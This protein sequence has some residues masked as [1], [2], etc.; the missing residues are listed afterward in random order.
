VS[1][2]RIPTPAPKVYTTP[3]VREGQK[4]ARPP[5]CCQRCGITPRGR[6]PRMYV[7]THPSGRPSIMVDGDCRTYL[8]H[9]GWTE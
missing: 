6:S 7:V 8:R 4:V 2:T 5:E 9:L 1:Q 3:A